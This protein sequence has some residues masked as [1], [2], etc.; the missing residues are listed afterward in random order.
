MPLSIS[1]TTP[2]TGAVA[3]YHV[4]TCVHLDYQNDAATAY[5]SSFLNESVRT[6]GKFA[7]YQQQIQLDGMP[8]TGQDAKDYAEANL[9][10]PIPDTPITPLSNRYSFA[11][12]AVVA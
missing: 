11:G 2:N 1:F 8:A 12:A 10:V 4:V 6:A 3:D 7:M 5:V 9:V